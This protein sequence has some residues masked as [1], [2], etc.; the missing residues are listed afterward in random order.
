MGSLNL[1]NF[2]GLIGWKVYVWG[3]WYKN[4]RI[5]DTLDRRT[6]INLGVYLDGRHIRQKK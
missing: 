3:I 4:I 2:V 5:A 1:R 6:A